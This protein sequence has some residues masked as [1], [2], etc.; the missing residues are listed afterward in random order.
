MK[1][2]RGP[3]S[4]YRCIDCGGQAEDWSTADRS[5]NDVRVRFQPRCRKCHRRY[6]GAIGEGSPRAKLTAEK[7][8]KLRARR[9]DGLTYR[10]LAGEFGISDVSAH[11][12]VNRTTWAHVA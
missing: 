10:Q 8:R 6:D 4:D 12:A 2:A 11:A 1:K 9:A 3:A 5:S 7:V